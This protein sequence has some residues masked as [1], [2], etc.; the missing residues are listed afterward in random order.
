MSPALPA[1]CHFA[2]FG[3]LAWV[4]LV[5]GWRS[6]DGDG[7]GMVKNSI[8]SFPFFDTFSSP[9]LSPHPIPHTFLFSSSTPRRNREKRRKKC[10]P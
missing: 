10:L 7:G 2:R 8:L 1:R 3:G 5:K 9:Y 4:G 6:G